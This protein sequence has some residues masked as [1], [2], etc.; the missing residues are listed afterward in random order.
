MG[1]VSRSSVPS[2]PSVHFRRLQTLGLQ[3]RE[4]PVPSLQEYL[5][6]RSERE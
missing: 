2:V 1:E 6:A 3:R 4:K 5:A